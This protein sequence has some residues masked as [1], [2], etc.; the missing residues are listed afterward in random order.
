RKPDPH[1]VSPLA[2]SATTATTRSAGT[3]AQATRTSWSGT[4]RGLSARLW[5]YVVVPPGREL[6][7]RNSEVPHGTTVLV[8]PHRRQPQRQRLRGLGLV[9]AADLDYLP[10]DLAVTV[11]RDHRLEGQLDR[12]QREL[13]PLA[14]ALSYRCDELGPQCTDGLSQPHQRLIHC[15]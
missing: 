8:P 2:S 14:A 10:A 15:S 12:L 4:G 9:R 13:H 1:C 11:L 6:C 5:A 7:V 3:P